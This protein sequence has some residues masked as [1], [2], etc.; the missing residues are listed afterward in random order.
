MHATYPE[1]QNHASLVRP[2]RRRA[3][4]GLSF[5]RA[6]PNGLGSD[7]RLL[8]REYCCGSVCILP[9]AHT[10]AVLDPD[11]PET[12]A[13][14]QRALPHFPQRGWER[15][16]LEP[17]LVKAPLPNALQLAACT[18]IHRPERLA[19]AK[20]AVAD[21]PDAARNSDFLQRT[22]TE[23]RLPDRLQPAVLCE[24]HHFEPRAVVERLDTDLKDTGRNSHALDA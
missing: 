17:A 8:R 13:A 16:L 20:R 15:Y 6:T 2:V 24:R 23:A 4:A 3:S 11:R 22:P 14:A 21:G 19:A 1:H 7:N 9:H 18:K 12:G 10:A 5:S